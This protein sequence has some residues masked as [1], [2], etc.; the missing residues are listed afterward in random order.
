MKPLYH[1]FIR[2]T[3]QWNVMKVVKQKNVVMKVTLYSEI[4]TRWL[5]EIRARRTSWGCL[6]IDEIKWPRAFRRAAEPLSLARKNAPEMW[7][8]CSGLHV[9]LNSC[10]PMQLA[11][12]S[13]INI[14]L[15]F[16]AEIGLSNA[17]DIH[18]AH[19]LST[20]CTCIQI[21]SV[22]YNQI[23]EIGGRSK[24]IGLQLVWCIMYISC[25]L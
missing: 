1:N 10:R 13:T 12:H 9:L 19:P 21:Q 24:T 7:W 8:H 11:G 5:Y 6:S 20:A 17:S 14:G 16:Y 18:C 25:T 23:I 3:T 4:I 15:N 22:A 2:I